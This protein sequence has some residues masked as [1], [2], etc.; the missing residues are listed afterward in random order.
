MSSHFC[1]V[2]KTIPNLGKLFHLKDISVKFIEVVYES[3]SKDLDEA[4]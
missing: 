1:K 3:N 4:S 2:G